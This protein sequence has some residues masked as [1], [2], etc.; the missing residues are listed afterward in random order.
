[1]AQELRNITIGSPGFFGL[2]TE[3]SPIGLDVNFAGTADNAVV[4]RF[5]RL[6]ARKGFNLQTASD[7]LLNDKNV[8]NIN[9][10]EDESGNTEIFVTANQ[11]IFEVSTVTTTNDTLTDVTPGSY[12]PSSDNWTILNFN[13]NCYFFQ[14]GLEPAVYNDTLGA[15][16]KMSS[17][18]GWAAPSGRSYPDGDIAIAA[19]GRLWVAGFS[20]DKT[21]V[22]WSDLLNGVNW[23]GGS[24]GSIDLTTVWPDG[25]DEVTGLAAYNDLLI[26]FG[27]NSIVVYSGAASPASMTLSDT[28]SGVGCLSHRSIKDT[29]TDLVYLSQTGL[30]SF[31][32]TVQG[33][34]MPVSDVSNNIRK[35][36]I[37]LTQSKSAHQIDAA[38]HPEEAFYVLSIRGGDESTTSTTYCFDM[39][40]RLPDGTY[41]VTRWPSSPF[42]TFHSYEGTLYVGNTK[43]LGTY[44]GYQDTG[45]E[46]TSYRFK[47]YSVILT[48]EQAARL[49]FLKQ[50]RPV[51][52][53][54]SVTSA[55]VYWGYGFDNSYTSQVV[56]FDTSGSSEWGEAEWGLGEFS[57]GTSF[58][59]PRVKAT[60]SGANLSIGIEATIDGGFLSLQEINVQTLLGRLR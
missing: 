32:R 5:G 34:A 26:I 59:E 7:T 35:D 18:G 49:K 51:F 13:N 14:Q 40:N 12:S 41:R 53:T 17:V 60:G 8:S 21:T 11:K 43:G 29:G 22:H 56:T 52:I 19:Y 20:D 39:R 3:D 50:I 23:S 10:F 31:S 36:L 44:S 4:D 48:F 28:I 15:V 58:S 27:R 25:Y 46:S 38:F 42:Y 24:S 57:G 33:G 16:T 30:R 6:G 55:T 45:G 54:E 37:A 9:V 47:W 2:N 1:M